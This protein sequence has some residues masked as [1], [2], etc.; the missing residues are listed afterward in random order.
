MYDNYVL[1]VEDEASLNIV[2]HAEV[3]VGLFD[4]DDI[5]EPNWVVSVGADLAIDLDEALHEDLLDFLL[6]QGV[7]QSVTEDEHKRK[8][9]TELV[10]ASGR[11]RCPGSTHLVQH[12]VLRGIQTFQMFLWSTSHGALLCELDRGASCQRGPPDWAS[13]CEVLPW[14]EEGIYE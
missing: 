10:R 13:E 7:L 3:L 5:H 6:G 4:G 14:V 12:P 1:P 11:A 2:E 9:L 8:A